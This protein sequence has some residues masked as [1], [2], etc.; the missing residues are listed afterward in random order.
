MIDNYVD[1]NALAHLAK[2]QN[3]VKVLLLTKTI[4]RELSLDVQKADAQYGGFSVKPFTPSHDRFLII[5]GGKEV[6]HI[7]ASLKD[8]GKKW[9]AFSKLNKD[10]V[11][12]IINVV[13]GFM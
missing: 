1:E 13:S 8:L 2:K 12:N 9:F 5:D 7:G 3:G 6:Y 11:A 4:S 10:T